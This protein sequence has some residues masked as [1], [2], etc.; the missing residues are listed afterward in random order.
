MNA[1]WILLKHSLRRI[2]TLLLVM[3]VVL[4]VFQVFLIVVARSLYLS[5]AFEQIN[6]LAPPFARELL[7]PSIA[8][9]LTF[10]GIVCV[11][12]FHIAVMGALVAFAIA[13]STI[14]TAEIELGFIDLILSRSLARHW[15]I[16]RTIVLQ[17]I[18]LLFLLVMMLLGTYAGLRALSPQEVTGPSR[19]LVLSLAG[20][21]GLLIL[22]WAGVALAIGSI[23]RR[24][25]VAG[26]FAGL[27]ALVTFLL[28]YVAR[29]WK[30]AQSVAWLSPFRYF[31]PFDLLMGK[32]LPDKNLIMLSGVAITGFLL[33]YVFFS[34]RDIT[35]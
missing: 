12:Y 10:T 32:P 18:S 35:R 28:D 4:A 6:A 24:R 15:L 25:S 2:R 17:V 14:P 5:N 29:A 30:P 1:S 34:R 13:V 27:L 16:T 19:E 33:S 11:G 3:G 22:C 26:A 8:T 20:N 9:F 31:S 7:G 23:S 21:L